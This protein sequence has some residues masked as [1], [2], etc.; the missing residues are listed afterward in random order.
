MIHVVASIR[1]KAGRGPEFLEIFKAN[2]PS[3][4]A[5]IGCMAYA[6]TVDVDVDLKPQLLDANVV[7][8]LEKWESAETL[9]AHLASPHMLAYRDKVADL[10]ED[11]SIKVL[12]EV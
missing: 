10:V 1:V 5:E 4:R 11:V 8:I 3:V 9:H 7:T 12:R 6:P 2:V